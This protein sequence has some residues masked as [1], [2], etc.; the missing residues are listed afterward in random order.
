MVRIDKRANGV[1][2]VS[3]TTG[4]VWWWNSD[5][6][7]GVQYSAFQPIYVDDDEPMDDETW[8]DVGGPP[9]SDGTPPDMTL[10]HISL[11][12]NARGGGVTGLDAV[13]RLALAVL[14]GDKEAAGM[15]ADAVLAGEA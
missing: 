2:V 5:E 10:G 13:R 4:K 6:P 7:V 12:V 8:P 1:I 15:L 9:K 3:F 11:A 14:C